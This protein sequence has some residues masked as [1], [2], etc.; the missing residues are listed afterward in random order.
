MLFSCKSVRCGLAN[1]ANV[2][3]SGGDGKLISFR[4]LEGEGRVVSRFAPG[5]LFVT[6]LGNVIALSAVK[7]Y[8]GVIIIGVGRNVGKK[9]ENVCEGR[10]LF[11][12]IV[13]KNRA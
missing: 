9:N 1:N 12:E 10:G 8:L 7:L 3:L 13:F 5:Y 2:G 11:G 4:I 6:A